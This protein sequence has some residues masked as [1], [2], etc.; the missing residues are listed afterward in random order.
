MNI[1]CKLKRSATHVSSRMPLFLK[2]TMAWDTQRTATFV[3]ICSCSFHGFKFC[4]H[5]VHGFYISK[6]P[7]HLVLVCRSEGGLQRGISCKG[8][9]D[10]GVRVGPPKTAGSVS[11][12]NVIQNNF[13]GGANV[14]GIKRPPQVDS[15]LI[16]KYNPSPKGPP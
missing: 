14:T 9:S 6:A 8:G 11:C 12:F 2:C 1:W 10:F 4:K 16:P 5:W 7:L 3:S 13:C 15:K